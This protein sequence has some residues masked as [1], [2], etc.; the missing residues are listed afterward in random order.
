VDQPAP[1]PNWIDDVLRHIPLFSG[2]SVAELEALCRSGSHITV[3]PGELAIEEGK[4]GDTLL[5]VLSGELEITKREG[6]REIVLASRK[7][8][9][10]LGEMALLERS[11]R[12][13]SARAVRETELLVIGP[14]A[15]K[16][17]LES[18]PAT[19]T[20]ILRTVA[21]RLR[22]TEASLV[23]SDRL[24]ALGTLAAGL[25]HELNNPAAA[26]QSS[27]AY[28]REAFE[29]W[30]RR[31]ADLARLELGSEERGHIADLE[32]E[33]GRELGQQRPVGADQLAVLHARHRHVAVDADGEL[34]GLD[35]LGR[36]RHGRAGGEREGAD[37]E[38]PAEAAQ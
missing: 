4:P 32:A 11:P 13:A 10:F 6:D 17:L 21:S 30:R 19:A 8:G 29:K 5:V 12:S 38:R 16:T 26:I 36:L 25:A 23:Q 3:R 31:T 27:S 37:D 24:A 7:A 18:T 1:G 34:A 15:F 35:G 9:E 33:I 14:E 28:L 22:S 2:L 20:T